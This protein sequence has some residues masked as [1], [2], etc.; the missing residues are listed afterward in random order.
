M[1][2]GPKTKKGRNSYKSRRR[3][4]NNR[5]ELA[6]ACKTQS[7]PVTVIKLTPEEVAEMIRRSK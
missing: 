3:R 7:G 5:A 4:E 1:M 6:R 2:V